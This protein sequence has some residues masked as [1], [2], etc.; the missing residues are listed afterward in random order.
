MEKI[1]IYTAIYGAFDDLKRQPVCPEADYFC[2]TDDAVAAVEP[3]SIITSEPRYDHPR[4]AAKWFKMHPHVALP[5]YRYTIW[6]DGNVKVKTAAFARE[7]MQWL[8]S[9]GI[10]VLRH[11]DRDNI[12]DEAE[13]SLT[14]TRYRGQP[15]AE[16]IEH[17]RSL[18]FRSTNGLHY[19]GVILRDSAN[20]SI[21]TLNEA[22]ME[23]NLRWSYQDQVSFPF[24]LGRYEITPDV[25]PLEMR[26]NHL[27]ERIRHPRP[28]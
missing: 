22:W 21:R 18:G 7:I 16:Q 24:L 14:L 2:F 8:G 20:E 11:P 5:E 4:M 6:I 26:D 12:F 10:S 23:E 25:I 17:Y 27:F 19:C 15:I 28:D 3:W 9:S 1:A 13:Y